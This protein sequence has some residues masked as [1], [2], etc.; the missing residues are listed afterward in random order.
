MYITR[1]RFELTVSFNVFLFVHK[2]K[3]CHKQKPV[4]YHVLHVLKN[5]CPLHTRHSLHI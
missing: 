4:K 5:S 2:I 1:Q 3:L